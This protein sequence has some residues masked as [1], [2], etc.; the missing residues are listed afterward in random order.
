MLRRPPRAT[1]SDTLF[2]YTALFRSYIEVM[3]AP[4]EHDDLENAF[5]VD[6][7]LTYSGTATGTLTG[8][9]HLEGQMV[10]VLAINKR[11]EEHTSELQSLM[12]I[13][14]AGFCLKKKKYTTIKM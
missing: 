4:F 7:G 13:S 14:Y 10:E 3:Q 11:S 9:S 2:P 5:E 8:L 1:R 12:R 6:C